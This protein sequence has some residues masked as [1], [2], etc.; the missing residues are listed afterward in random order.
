MSGG[1][2]SMHL[3]ADVFEDTGSSHFLAQSAA[4]RGQAGLSALIHPAG[5]LMQF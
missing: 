1:E 5:F 2:N 3:T 4:S